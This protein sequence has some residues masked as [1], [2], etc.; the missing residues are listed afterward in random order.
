L[1]NIDHSQQLVLELFGVTNRGGLS[2][3]LDQ[4]GVLC[5]EILK[6]LPIY[7]LVPGDQIT[8][9]LIYSILLSLRVEGRKIDYAKGHFLSPLERGWGV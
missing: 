7:G 5:S 6:T 2:D 4:K 3:L 8:T 1:G 9:Y